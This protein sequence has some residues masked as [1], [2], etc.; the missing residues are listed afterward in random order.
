[1]D[2]ALAEAALD[3]EEEELQ[4]S[5]ESVSSDG[6]FDELDDDGIDELMER[7]HDP[8]FGADEV[9]RWTI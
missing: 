6:R 1:M 2:L 5:S 4:E 3:P 7:M 8:R 9:P